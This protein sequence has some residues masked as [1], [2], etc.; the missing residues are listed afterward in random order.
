[1]SECHRGV[2]VRALSVLL[3]R[4]LWAWYGHDVDP[5]FLSDPIAIIASVPRMLASAGQNC[6][7][8][9]GYAADPVNQRQNGNL[10][11]PCEIIDRWAWLT[12]TNSCNGF[13]VSN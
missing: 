11:R 1:L 9:D 5:I 7:R 12:N 13:Q 4:A 3:T 6:R 10:A 2:L 8:N